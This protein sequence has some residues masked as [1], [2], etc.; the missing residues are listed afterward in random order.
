[1]KKR[2]AF[3]VCIFCLIC[4]C[5]Q[6]VGQEMKITF[7][8]VEKA[9]M[10]LLQTENSVVVIDTGKDSAGKM[11]VEHLEKEGIAHVDML[12]ITHFDKDHVGGAD[13]LLSE[14]SVGYV[15]E[16]DYAKESKQ[17]TQYR[18]ALAKNGAALLVLSENYS[19]ELDGVQ[20]LV[21]VANSSYYGDDEENDFSLVISMT[22]DGTRLLF[23]G[24]AENPRLKELIFEGDL[25]HDILK[26]PHHG[27]WEKSS[28]AF[29]A[30]VQ[31]RYSII[32]SDDKE[33]EDQAVVDLLT[34]QGSEVFLT[35]QGMVVCTIRDGSIAFTQER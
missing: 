15:F 12:F 25:K 4:V 27:R 10:F 34:A 7:F 9:D 11:L 14:V 23:T 6:A 29:F 19:I 3:W 17:V 18:Q 26:V 13:T 32:T 8:Q 30:A 31:P 24:D 28:A 35:R 20:Y 2:L 16:P 21:D 22:Y 33:L 5:A 1:M